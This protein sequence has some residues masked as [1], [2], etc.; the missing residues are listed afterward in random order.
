MSLFSLAMHNWSQWRPWLRKTWLKNYQP[1]K[2]SFDDKFINAITTW[3]KYDTIIDKKWK[4]SC[5]NGCW[6]M[7]THN[8]NEIENEDWLC[9]FWLDAIQDG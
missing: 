5:C 3:W 6:C 8:Y 4:W 7:E 9:N 2:E 1:K